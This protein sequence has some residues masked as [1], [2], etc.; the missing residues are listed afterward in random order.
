MNFRICLSFLFFVGI[1]ATESAAEKEDL[2]F[3]ASP[4]ALEGAHWTRA[5]F[6]I[7]AAESETE[8]RIFLSS[9]PAEQM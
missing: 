9:V 2:C 7:K 5:G 4:H 1:E 6:Q 8:L 3:M